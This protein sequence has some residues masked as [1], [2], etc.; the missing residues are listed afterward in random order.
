I[1]LFSFIEFNDFLLKINE[2]V[3]KKGIKEFNMVIY[4]ISW[5]FD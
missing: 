1:T 3:L 5:C 2:R 4:V